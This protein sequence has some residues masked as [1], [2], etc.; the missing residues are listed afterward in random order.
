MQMQKAILN[1]K[2]KK[3]AHYNFN[4]PKKLIKEI[5]RHTN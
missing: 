4:K 2:L 5:R 1:C 3:H